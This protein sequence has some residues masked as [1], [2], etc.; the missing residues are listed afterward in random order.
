M[1]GNT[2]AIYNL[3]LHP[4]GF[5]V[6]P[7]LV[8]SRTGVSA[9]LI[10]LIVLGV[11][12]A[13]RFRLQQCVQGFLYRPAYNLCQLRLHQLLIDLYNLNW[14]RGLVLVGHV[15]LLLVCLFCSIQIKSDEDPFF[16]PTSNVRKI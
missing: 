5:R 4:S 9:Y 7:S 6:Q 12:Q 14:F 11:A 16:Y 2:L 1:G 13:V 10:S 15:V 8:A 3:Q